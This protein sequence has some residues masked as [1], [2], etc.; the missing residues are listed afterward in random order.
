MSR[1]VFGDPRYIEVGYVDD[2][3]FVRF[4]CIAETPRYEP[5]APWEEQEGPEY[6]ALETEIARTQAQL[7]KRNLMSLLRYHNESMDGE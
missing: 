4:D 2:T 3:Q 1:P 5:R 7:S 6:W